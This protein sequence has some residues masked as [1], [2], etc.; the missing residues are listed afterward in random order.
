MDT[1][2]AY[3]ANTV[4]RAGEQGRAPPLSIAQGRSSPRSPTMGTAIAAWLHKTRAGTGQVLIKDPVTLTL[5]IRELAF[6]KSI[7]RK[8]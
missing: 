3:S 1:L 2:A 6:M 8:K 4:H 7:Q 5:A